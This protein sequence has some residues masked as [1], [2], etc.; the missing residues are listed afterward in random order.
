VPA[1]TA[2]AEISFVRSWPVGALATKPNVP[3]RSTSRNVRS[4][5]EPAKTLATAKAPT[6]AAS[7]AAYE[8]GLVQPGAG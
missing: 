3:P 6:A 4:P 1:E 5:A 8:S 7:I 2:P